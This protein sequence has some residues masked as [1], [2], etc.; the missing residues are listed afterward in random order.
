MNHI[1]KSLLNTV[2]NI[3][4]PTLFKNMTKQLWSQ[5]LLKMKFIFTE[6]VKV[7]SYCMFQDSGITYSYLF[8]F[9]CYITCL[10]MAI[11]V[12]TTQ[13][14]KYF[15]TNICSR[16]FITFLVHFPRSKLHSSIYPKIS[17]FA[18]NLRFS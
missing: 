15:L 16:K 14:N 1:H 8:C 11:T 5:K 9:M 7:L 13:R 4:L 6:L 10:L 3:I 18:G 17:Y 2:P 12:I